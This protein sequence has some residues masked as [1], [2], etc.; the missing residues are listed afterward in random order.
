[1][2][3]LRIGSRGEDVKTL[4]KYLGLNPDGIYGLNTYKKVVIWQ[5][6]KG[7]VPDGIIGTKSWEIILSKQSTTPTTTTT[8]QTKIS[9]ENIGIS[10]GMINFI[11]KYETGKSFGYRMSSRDKT[12]Y[13]L[14][15]AKGHKTYGYGLLCHPNG[16]YM[17]DIK[18]VWTQKEL[19]DLYI[20]YAKKVSAKIDAWASKNKVKLNQNQKDAIASACYN[21]GNGFL[22]KNICKMI[23][24]NPND[25]AI[26]TTW[27][28]LSDAQGKKYPGLIIRR[29][30]EAKWYFEGK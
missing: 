28:H 12:G 11:C 5:K 18:S 16:G 3:T 15:D 4:Q 23:I 30:A 9:S 21:F 17:D 24:K 8:V 25:P 1:M 19:E 22:N 10:D 14:H 27:E 2:N 13:D 7:L 29:K 6:S 26:R 20:L